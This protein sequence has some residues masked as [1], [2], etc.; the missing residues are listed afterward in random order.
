[1]PD[2]GTQVITFT[3][4]D[5]LKRQLEDLGYI[6]TA[7]SQ[8]RYTVNLLLKDENPDELLFD[9]GSKEIDVY[10]KMLRDDTV[11]SA[12][13]RKC[14][15][16]IALEY[17]VHGEE[18]PTPDEQA[19]V[20]F[21]RYALGNF[22]TRG[23][24]HLSI[25][26]FQQAVWDLSQALV[27]GYSI[28][29]IVLGY[30]QKGRWRGFTGLR[31][32]KSKDPL[33]YGFDLDEFNNIRAVAEDVDGVQKS[34]P[35]QKFVIFPYLQQYAN[36]HGTSDLRAAYRGF[37]L[38][39]SLYKWWLAG[40]EKYGTG[41]L[42]GRYP[43]GTS[44]NQ[45][46][47]FL[48]GLRRLKNESVSVIPE[49]MNV[50]TVTMSNSGSVFDQLRDAADKSIMQA[51]EGAFLHAAEGK[52]T[53]ARNM[54]L[55]HQ[56]TATRFVWLL[57]GLLAEI[58][59]DQLIPKLIDINFSGVERYPVFQYVEPG[60]VDI[61]TDMSIV[62]KVV[63]MGLPVARK[64]VYEKTGIPEPREGDD[65]LEAPKLTEPPG[66]GPSGLGLPFQVKEFA[67]DTSERD[68]IVERRDAGAIREGLSTVSD[69]IDTIRK[70]VAEG[71]EST[72]PDALQDLIQKLLVFVRQPG[73]D[74][75]ITD[76]A[77]QLERAMTHADLVGRVKVGEDI[78]KSR[79]QK[80]TADTALQFAAV[81]PLLGSFSPQD[82]F[83]FIKNKIPMTR[84]QFDGLMDRYRQYAFT[85][86]R[87]T[88][89]KQ[90]AD[91]KLFLERSISEGWTRRRFLKE[92]ETQFSKGYLNLVFQNNVHAA[93][94]SG[95]RDMLLNNDIDDIA[96]TLSIQTV[97]DRRVRGTPG[98]INEAEP[99]DD[100]FKLD[101][102]TAERGDPIWR[103]LW[104][105][106]SWNCRCTSISNLPGQALVS[107][108]G[109]YGWTFL[110]KFTAP[111][112]GG[113]I[114]DVEATGALAARV[115]GVF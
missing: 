14:S 90:V 52:L 20:E 38:K 11:S 102:F 16:V 72:S 44:Q 5:A 10:Q 103:K 15:A 29:E 114:R 87:A 89:L 57:A 4:S 2:N 105:P 3:G 92:F 107:P 35:W 73:F 21:I 104:P 42:I 98:G 34:H 65:L 6:E 99:Q 62:E 47:A 28:L 37:V 88:S 81:T 76:F 110:P 19:H 13:K 26:G 80:N 8:P 69:L 40:V 60:D 108:P 54:G 78:D 74:A 111:T 67:A 23:H 46:D 61:M 18:D 33:D 112:P 31:A 41:F 1:M 66:G 12:L 51:I 79:G 93:F 64:H 55:V 68:Q 71:E 113:A 58:I 50:E 49:G 43:K 115:L 30:I 48:S 36:P 24:E 100:H 45:I 59:N 91:M 101:G 82:A 70:R 63:G 39:R 22:Q 109:H 77:E 53:G 95:K 96:P 106:F 83:D 94:E 86:S 9:L 27:A 7:L 75:G 85:A 17:S 97:G 25:G 84:A 32:L 56:D